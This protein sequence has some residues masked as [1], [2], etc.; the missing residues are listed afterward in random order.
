MKNNIFLAPFI[1]AVAMVPAYAA[2]PAS[3]ESCIVEVCMLDG[4]AATVEMNES[5]TDWKAANYSSMYLHFPRGCSNR[6]SYQLSESTPDSPWPPVVVTYQPAKSLITITGNDMHVD[7]QLRFS[8]ANAGTA[9]FTWHDECGS[10]YIR[11]A[12]F[13]VRKT[14]VTAGLV[15]MPQEAET[16]GAVQSVDDGLGELV[17]ELEQ[18]QYKTAVERLYQKR[19]LTLLPQIM[20]GADVN[21]VLPNA[22]GTTA[23]HN[24]CGLSHVEIV[25]WLVNHGADLN[26]RTAKGASVETCVGGPNA[27]AINAIL[28]QARN[29]K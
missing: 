26:A 3:L 25:Q 28:R 20:E 27:K 5:P 21:S 14:A 17:R 13:T 29:S 12:T 10:L 16:D 9:T 11:G 24:A 15:I 23:L 2:A 7:V 6:F 19:L 18:R 1:A 22:N 4:Q 8:S